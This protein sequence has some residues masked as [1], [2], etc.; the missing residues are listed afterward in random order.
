MINKQKTKQL[1]KFNIKVDYE[2]EVKVFDLMLVEI[3]QAT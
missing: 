1:S 3:T 2:P